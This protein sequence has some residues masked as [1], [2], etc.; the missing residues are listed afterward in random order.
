MCVSNY[1]YNLYKLKTY[2][3]KTIYITT[4]LRLPAIFIFKLL[5]QK[6]TLFR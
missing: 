1:V 4:K 3:R 2:S 5:E 6:K